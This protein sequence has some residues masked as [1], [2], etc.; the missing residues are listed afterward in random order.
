MD[1]SRDSLL[2]YARNAVSFEFLN[3]G[4]VLALIDNVGKGSRQIGCVVFAICL[5]IMSID[6]PS[7]PNVHLTRVNY[8]LG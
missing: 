4:V 7:A 5:L 1:L 3:L 2:R 6:S 8:T